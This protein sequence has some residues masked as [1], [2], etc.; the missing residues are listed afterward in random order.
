MHMYVLSRV[1]LFVIPWTVACQAPLSMG[2][3]WQ[4]YWSGLP[5]PPPGSLPVPGGSNPYLLCL[6]HW[7]AD[8]LP[9]SHLG[10]PNCI[11]VC[12]RARACVCVCVCVLAALPSL[13]DFRSPTRDQPELPAVEAWSP[14]H[15]T[16]REVPIC[17]FVCIYIYIG[18]LFKGSMP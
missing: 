6:L 11:Y 15:W 18:I 7:Q 2:F 12:V 10:S 9:L 4:E 8:S 13:P 5:F 17:I 3:S 1:Q 14:N 16:T